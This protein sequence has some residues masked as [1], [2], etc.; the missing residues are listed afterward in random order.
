MR[1][2]S[3]MSM[4][5]I[6]LIGILGAYLG[7][8][9]AAD[10]GSQPAASVTTSHVSVLTGDQVVQ[11]LDQTV[12]WYR[13]LGT[14]QQ[15]ASQPSDL[16]IL[17]ANQQTASQVVGLAFDIARANAELLSS[18][19]SSG[20]SAADTTSSSQALIAQQKKLQAQRLTIH[21]I[22]S[23]NWDGPTRY[24]V[25]THSELIGGEGGVPWDTGATASKKGFAPRLGLA[26]RLRPNSVIRAGYGI[27]ID[28]DNM[29][30]QRNA[31]PSV[32]NQDFQPANSYQFI[33]N[34]GVP[35][36]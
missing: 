19:A 35:Q 7:C 1:Y 25:A 18:E 30:N 23:H 36:A 21:P 32:L 20:Q 17:Y 22:F 11:I 6:G 8:A 3:P 14:Q 29:R 31:F 13:T 12:E 33:T 15:T 28:P 10:E 16:L 4:Y 26:Y 24:D 34:S 5:R 2:D 9:C 27:T